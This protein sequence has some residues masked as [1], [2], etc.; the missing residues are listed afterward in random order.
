MMKNICAAL[1]FI[2]LS[3]RGILAQ[4][5][6]ILRELESIDLIELME[7]NR[8]HVRRVQSVDFDGENNLYVLDDVSGSV[9]SLNLNTGALVRKISSKGQGPAELM[10]PSVIRVIDKK[11]FVLSEGHGAV[12]IF[13]VDGDYLGGFKTKNIPRWMEVDDEENIYIAETDSEANPVIS[14]YDPDGKEVKTAITFKLDKKV[15]EDK[16]QYFMHSMMKFRLDAQGNIIL[17]AFLLREL[18]KF[19]SDGSPL[20]DRKIENS[21]IEPFLKNEGVRNDRGRPLFRGIVFSFD[22]DQQGNIVVGHSGGGCVYNAKGD[23]TCLLEIQSTEQ[24]EIPPP[25]YIV[26]IFGENI[27]ATYHDGTTH[28]FKYKLNGN[29]N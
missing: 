17:L 11:I 24:R 10:M 29:Q 8:I 23:L 20:W 2:A 15:L 9:I 14:V 3:S 26:K 13:S 18:R 5:K 22:I 16:A 19:T 6:I 25:L 28:I 21:V 27:L 12:K 4:E 7:Q 1:V